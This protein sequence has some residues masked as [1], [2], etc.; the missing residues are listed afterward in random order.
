VALEIS[1]LAA[2]AVDQS[3][4]NDNHGVGN[5]SSSVGPVA[6][7]AANEILLGVT[8]IDG[9]AGLTAGAGYTIPLGGTIGT[10]QELGVEYQIVSS[11]G[12]YSATMGFRYA[13]WNMGLVTLK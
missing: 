2:S 13:N 3:I 5:A 11:T 1:G 6:T 10:S 9:N 7:T 8:A 4:N 12:S